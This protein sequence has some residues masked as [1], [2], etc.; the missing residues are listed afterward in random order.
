[1]PN[2]DDDDP[3]VI[4]LENDRAARL[5]FKDIEDINS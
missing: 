5:T 1:M 3:Y 2:S 4:V